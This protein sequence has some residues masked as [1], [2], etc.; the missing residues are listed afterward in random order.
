MGPAIG[1]HVA[2]LVQGKAQPYQL[3]ALHRLQPRPS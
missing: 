2:S 1:E 3:F